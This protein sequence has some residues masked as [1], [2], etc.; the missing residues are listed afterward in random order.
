L[1]SRK[2][3]A[4]CGKVTSL[5][6]TVNAQCAE[7]LPAAFSIGVGTTRIVFVESMTVISEI[8]H[9]KSGS[10]GT[11]DKSGYPGV[12]NQLRALGLETEI[13][14]L[15]TENCLFSRQPHQNL[16]RWPANHQHLPQVFR[17]KIRPRTT[18]EVPFRLIA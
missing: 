15:M 14:Q 9:Q 12:V 11:S 4:S 16:P 10:V 7:N 5:F 8:R 3:F 2:K 13:L 1:I 18:R 6:L 17:G